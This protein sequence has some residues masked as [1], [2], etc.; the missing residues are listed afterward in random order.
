MVRCLRWL[1]RVVRC[2]SGA[3]QS[4]GALVQINFAKSQS[5]LPH[6]D[7]R[8]RLV[9]IDFLRVTPICLEMEQLLQVVPDS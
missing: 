8:R 3:L 1:C 6:Q 7:L 9:V 2:G 4:T 5:L